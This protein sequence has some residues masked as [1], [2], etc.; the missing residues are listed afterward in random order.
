[1]S[2]FF[3]LICCCISE[4]LLFYD[5][6]VSRYETGPSALRSGEKCTMGKLFS[7]M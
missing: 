2:I 4:Q 6:L 3:A 1:M 5:I 7:V